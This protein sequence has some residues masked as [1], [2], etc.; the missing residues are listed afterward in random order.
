M[1]DRTL[2]EIMRDA[3]QRPMERHY[4]SAHLYGAATDAG[5]GE[6][7]EELEALDAELWCLPAGD[8]EAE[9]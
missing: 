6:L 3:G 5:P 7:R 8:L 1:A 9:A 4:L 2:G